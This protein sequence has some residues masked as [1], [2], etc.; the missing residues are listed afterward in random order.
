MNDHHD[1]LAGVHVA[2]V[3]PFRDDRDRAVDIDA[4]L[5]H[6]AWL[7]Q[8]GIDGVVCFGTNGEGPS[9]SAGEKQDA[10]ERVVAADLGVAIIPTVTESTLPDTVA[11][12]ER[13]NDLDV[14]AVMV[15]PPYYF[16]PAPAEGLRAFYDDVIPVSRHPFIVYHIPKYAVA[17]PPQLVV[18][19]PVWG[20]KDSGGESGY[21]E[22][23]LAGGSGVLLGTEDA[24]R[25]GL[26]KGAQGL[27]S[28]LANVV[29]EQLVALYD[30]VRSGDDT[31]AAEIEKGLLE[32]RARTKEY[33]SPGVLKQ[34]A[35]F[36]HGH[37]MGTVRPPLVPVP[38]GYDA[39]G[40]LAVAGVS[41]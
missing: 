8:S 4:Y 14:A 3:T 18:D 1:A 38:A 24:I 39:A 37:P 19:L 10:I 30:A 23:V 27:I 29:P 13:L 34:L 2:A 21:A 22:H 32:L 36:R 25:A 16:K 28:A 6:L 26:A 31:A 12:L 41:S 7:A 11:Q 33:A 9:M 5:A 17:V 20:V 40:A 15:L 35:E